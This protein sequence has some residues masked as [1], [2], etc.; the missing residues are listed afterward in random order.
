MCQDG[1]K[2]IQYHGMKILQRLSLT[3]LMR[4]KK[5]TK[6]AEIET[7]GHLEI[8]RIT[9]VDVAGIKEEDS[10]GSVVD[11]DDMKE[12]RVKTKSNLKNKSHSKLLENIH[13]LKRIA[14]LQSRQKHQLNQNPLLYQFES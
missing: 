12:L 5:N 8:I 14:L 11:T 1:M 13:I 7:V 3:L 9:G 6:N 2:R 4:I 10:E